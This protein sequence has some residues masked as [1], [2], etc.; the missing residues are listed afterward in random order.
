MSTAGTESLRL[1]ATA[2]LLGGLTVVLL[3]PSVDG[4]VLT[5]SDREQHEGI[6]FNIVRHGE[7]RP[8]DVSYEA[9]GERLSEAYSRREPGYPLYLAS[10]FATFPAIDSL[11]RTCISD[12]GCEAA[13][14][15]RRRVQR[16][17]VVVAAVTVAATL[18]ATYAFTAG[19]S[20]SIVAGL[21]YLMLLPQ[22]IPSLLAAL[23]LL[24]HAALAADMW[25]RSS[26]ISGAL[27]GIALGL[28]VLTK[29]VF[30]YWLVGLALLWL[31]ATWRHSRPPRATMRAFAALLVAAWS[32]TLPWMVR[33]AVH[34]GQHGVAG[35][36]GQILAIRAEYGRM[37]WPEV[38]GAL[39]YYLPVPDS[40]GAVRD[41]ALRWLE[42]R[43]FG[44]ARFDRTNLAGFYRRA[45]DR[46]GDVAARADLIQPGWRLSDPTGM[47]SAERRAA[48]QL[49]GEDWL[50]HLALT[51]VFLARGSAFFDGGWIARVESYDWK[52]TVPIR[53]AANLAR[54][55]SYLFLP[56]LALS[57]VLAW[58][59][60]DAA[61]ALL[62][63]PVVYGLGIHAVA[64]HFV[65]RYSHPLV[66]V[67]V[68]VTA[69]A[70][71]AAW[72][73]LGLPVP[74]MSGAGL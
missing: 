17:T 36:G 6:A 33:N 40:A 52:S 28:L 16:L 10:I 45:K 2:A 25:R 42:P 53:Y 7:F 41:F 11:S 26:A 21:L 18:V 51:P 68:V 14:P 20:T 5:A 32:L 49:I 67:L 31:P 35:R 73:W 72:R 3:W 19:W 48:F 65:S 43:P 1:A 9:G 13:V 74:R 23:F 12:P 22:D 27:S 50:K 54:A 55:S 15:L 38:R 69:L 46:T 44:Y 64:T 70:A 56:A 71:Q 34:G 29:A 47:D 66:P 58:R 61:V 8:F 62:L 30:Q 63:S 4:L 60:R 39:A 57:L 59:R 37:T 24:G